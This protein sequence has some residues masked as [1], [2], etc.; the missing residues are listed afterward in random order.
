MLIFIICGIAIK[1]KALYI[2]SIVNIT[3]IEI[4]IIEI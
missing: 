3:K 4:R 2:Y 1:L